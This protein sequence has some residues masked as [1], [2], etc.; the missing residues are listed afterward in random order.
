MRETRATRATQADGATGAEDVGKLLESEQDRMAMEIVRAIRRILRKTAEHSRGLEREFG[1]NAPQVLCLRAI[2]DHREAPDC[3]VPPEGANCIAEAELEGKGT[4]KEAAPKQTSGAQPV[5]G[6]SLATRVTVVGLAE[7]V[8]MP[9][10]T[11]SRIL[12]RL[13][14]AGCIQRRR[15]ED[16]RRR[17]Y[18]SLTD[19]GRAKLARVPTPLHEQFME[20]LRR[21][22]RAEQASVLDGL[23]RVVEM[24]DAADLDVSPV[25]TSEVDVA[26]QFSA[27]SSTP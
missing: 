27:R 7:A 9:V 25:I 19:Q 26:S 3:K 11:V 12:D 15:A 20:R 1:L 22:D 18:V 13:E 16:D 14:Q 10:A 23:Q 4:A 2:A 5:P 17:V 24:M 8:H 21:L 6:E